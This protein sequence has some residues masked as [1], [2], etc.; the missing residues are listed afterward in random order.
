MSLVPFAVPALLA[1]R[2]S[3]D[4]TPVMVPLALMVHCWLVP[5]WQSQ[6]MTW[7]PLVVPWPLASRH[8]LPY[9][10]S[11]LAAVWVQRCWVLPAQSHSWTRVPLV[12]LALGTSMQRPD[13]PPTSWTLCRGSLPPAG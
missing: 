13:C 6:M 2:H 9:T 3:P 8:L 5:L 10:C 1:S 7:V 12:V 4:W 11:C